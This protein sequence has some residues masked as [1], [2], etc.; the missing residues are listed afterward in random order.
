MINIINNAYDGMISGSTVSDVGLCYYDSFSET[1][2]ELSSIAVNECSIHPL[3]PVIRKY[4][5]VI[6]APTQIGSVIISATC[7]NIANVGAKIIIGEIAPQLS[8]F[9]NLIF[10]NE[11]KILNPVH[12]HLIPV[13]VY[14]EQLISSNIQSVLSIELTAE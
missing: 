9:D 10:Y 8:D 4:Y 5:L 7:N 1:I 3:A 12:G 6:N 11:A 2:M 13:W 14:I